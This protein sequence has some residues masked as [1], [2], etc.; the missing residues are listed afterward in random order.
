MLKVC[1]D[2][3]QTSLEKVLCSIFYKKHEKAKRSLY[4]T[5]VT[6]CTD[7]DYIND[8]MSVEVVGEFLLNRFNRLKGSAKTISRTYSVIKE[9]LELENGHE[10][11]KVIDKTLKKIIKELEYLDQAGVK[12]SRP[13]RLKHLIDL[14]GGINLKDLD[15]LFATIAV[16]GHCGMLRTANLTDGLKVED[17][18]WAEDCNSYS[19]T[20][21]RSK[22]ER[23]GG[24]R[25]LFFKKNGHPEVCPVVL[26]LKWFNKM[27]LWK[28][29][30]LHLFPSIKRY[31]FDFRK[32][33]SGDW[34][35]KRIK[36]AV[37]SLGLN[38]Q[39]YSGH[40][41]RSGGATDLFAS[42]VPYYAIKKRG[43]WT[44]DAALLY[45][46]DSLSADVMVFNAFADLVKV[47]LQH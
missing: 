43:H 16:V 37:S 13:L 25:Y 34:I 32:S 45:Y 6:F 26:M 9:G 4:L 7:K 29:N 28:S 19:I 41:L 30:D 10:I 21:H 1:Q 46:R 18:T 35:R 5:F 23:K 39:D 15:L 38:P 8:Q 3:S 40:S 24:P 22:T 2:Q 12:Q 42:G 36:E 17:V 27:N 31:G 11:D 47:E 14:Y 44:S 33:V 20:I